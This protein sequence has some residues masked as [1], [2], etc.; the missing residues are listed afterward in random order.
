M[1]TISCPGCGS[2]ARLFEGGFRY[3]CVACLVDGWRV[4]TPDDEP[5]WLARHWASPFH[6]VPML[7]EVVEF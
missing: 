1:E 2:P 7:R 6:R 4:V 3:V 5:L